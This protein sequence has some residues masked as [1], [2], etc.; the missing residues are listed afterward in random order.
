MMVMCAEPTPSA[1]P[2]IS[3]QGGRS[4]GSA[5]TTSFANVEMGETYPH[6]DLRP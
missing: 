2:G 5:T 1:L 4:A 3:P 6:I